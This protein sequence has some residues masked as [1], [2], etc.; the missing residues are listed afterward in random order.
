MN[1]SLKTKL[2]Q[3]LQSS[4]NFPIL[5]SEEHKLIKQLN[6]RY[7]LRGY[8]KEILD[9]VRRKIES[10]RK[11]VHLVAPPGAGKTIIG[12]QILS[13]LKSPGLILSPNTTI[14][15]QWS[16][17]LHLFTP[18]KSNLD[19][20][21][22]IGTHEDKPLKPITILT[23]QVLSTPGKE[24][25]YLENLA[26]QEWVQE[27]RAN[28]SLSIGEAE[29]RI[30]EIY[31]NNQAAYKKEISRHITKLRRKLSE[32]LDINEVL[33]KN[34]IEL[35]QSLR[36]QGVRTVIFDECHHL[37]DYWAAI[38]HHVVKMLDDPVVI[39]LTG[40]PPEGKSSKQSHRYSTLV[41]A[42][43]YQ[44]PTPALVR[45]KGLSPFQDLVYFT[46]PT[47]KEYEFLANQHKGFHKVIEELVGP[48]TE[49]AN[50]TIYDTAKDNKDIGV[51]DED[52][53]RHIANP[54]YSDFAT[55]DDLGM[56]NNYQV[57]D[58]NKNVSVILSWLFNQILY[59]SKHTGFEEF[60]SKKAKLADAMCRV[61]W[62]YKLPVPKEVKNSK[63]IVR[64][65]DI[66]DWMI[67]LEEF[68]ST[69]LKTSNDPENH[70]L[71]EKIKEV[72]RELGYGITEGGLRKQASSVDRV[73]AFSNSKGEAV[74][75]ILAIE[76]RNMQEDLRAIVVTD[77]EKMSSTSRKTIEGIFDEDAGGAIQVF[78]TLL[79]SPLS[80][81]LNPCLVS[82]SSLLTDK[83]ITDRFVNSATKLLRKKG[84]LLKL[85]IERLE[86]EQFDRVTSQSSDWEPRLYVRFATEIFESGITKCLIGTRGLFGEGWDSQALNTLVDLTS[87]TSPVTVKQLRGRSIRIQTEGK[88]A[89]SKVANNWDVVCIAPDLEKGLN[90]YQ[91]FSKKHK[92][93]FG[94]SDDGQIEKGV[95]HVHP[96]L[97]E[98]AQSEVFKKAKD[99][100]NEMAERAIDRDSTYKLWQVGREY[101][102]KVT[103]CV[104]VSPSEKLN[105][106]PPNL[107]MNISQKEHRA[108]LKSNLFHIVLESIVPGL[109]V[110]VLA[111]VLFHNHWITIAVTIIFSILT[112]KLAQTRY[113][114][115][116]ERFINATTRQGDDK[117][118]LYSISRALLSALKRQRLLNAS[119]NHRH[120]TVSNRSNGNTRIV[121]RSIDE[122]DIKVFLKSLK[123]LLSAISNQSYVVPRYSYQIERAENIELKANLDQFFDNYLNNKASKKLVS[124]HPIPQALA[125]SKLGRIAFLDAWKKY[126]SP[127]EILE[128]DKK[129][130]LVA[131]NFGIG[132]TVQDREIWD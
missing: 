124:Y 106:V 7:E 55:N 110:P 62:L 42:I 21:S 70:V 82:G 69:R 84:H 113:Y 14:Q 87:A 35:I 6:F 51:L 30:L 61:M 17:K 8:Q 31:Q 92:Q 63:T 46:N 33:H 75:E 20:N 122:K 119:V 77:F 47:Y 15:A 58:K 52:G 1:S 18:E 65:P 43:D 16:Q 101:R 22:L 64:P 96:D 27:L 3:E 28:R 71:Y 125:K 114:K 120:L 40:T 116:K 38:M 26:R 85:D 100:N 24:Q 34:A 95:G 108:Y 81:F 118:Y 13:H 115:L 37:T 74:T 86:D 132:P 39:A 12:L 126:V 49:E 59:E 128:A 123:E 10:G 25:E 117:A 98:I 9:L 78:R 5:D 57:R 23:Y 53:N 72:S 56:V 83:R 107:S 73:L 88:F 60:Q 104:E 105:I 127:A 76:F 79:E 2:E 80:A 94:I 11:E 121:L 44:V 29:I 90:D 111:M 67:L 19:L 50:Y 93:F 109:I 68:A 32:V 103:N 129:P 91:R 130:E 54:L 45:E 112:F 99:L 41:G 66:D 97:S 4:N 89:N 48:P 36:R 131:R 102:N